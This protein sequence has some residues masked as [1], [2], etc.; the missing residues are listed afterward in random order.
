M[1]R[2]LEDQGFVRQVNLV[3]RGIEPEER[4][5]Q[6][7]VAYERGWVDSLKAYDA[8]SLQPVDDIYYYS[9]G[10]QACAEYRWEDPSNRGVAPNPNYR[11]P[12][13]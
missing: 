10:W 3:K 7:D 5:R 9:R 4:E 8:T 2:T 12:R 1:T 6:R 13:T 11:I